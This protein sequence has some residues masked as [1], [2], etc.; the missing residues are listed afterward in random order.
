MLTKAQIFP[1]LFKD[2]WNAP[3]V[4]GQYANV[5]YSFF[6]QTPAYYLASSGSAAIDNAETDF[7]TTYINQNTVNSLNNYSGLPSAFYTSASAWMAV[8]NISITNV[9]D[10]NANANIA[11]MGASLK[12][13]AQSNQ[14]SY[15]TTVSSLLDTTNPYS[16]N[17]YFGDMWINTDVNTTAGYTNV[18]QNSA[19]QDGY[20]TILH[21]MGHALGL[22]HPNGDPNT[23]DMLHTVMS[24][25]TADILYDGQKWYPSEPM[26]YDVLAIQTLYG[27]DMTH[28]VG[29]NTP[30]YTFS[31]DPNKPD[32]KVIWDAGGTGDMIDASNQTLSV[33]I[34]MTPG[35]YSSIG[36]GDKDKAYIAIAYNVDGFGLEKN[37]IEN[38]SGGTANDELTGNDGDNLL[39]GNNGNDTLKGGIGNDTLNGGNNDDQLEGGEDKDE[40]N[41]NDG[42]DTLKGE[43][44]NDTL[45]GGIGDDTL[46]GCEDDDSLNGGEGNDIMNGD[47]GNDTVNGGIGYDILEGG[48]GNDTLYGGDNYDQLDGG[49]DDDRLEGEAGY[50]TLKGGSGSDVLKGGTGNDTLEGGDDGD[51]LD[52][53]E[54]NDLLDGGEGVDI[55]IGDVGND[56]LKGGDGND[57]LKA[58]AGNNLGGENDVLEGGEGIDTYQTDSGDKI[59]D[60]DGK[61]QVYFADNLLHGGTKKSG[62]TVWKDAD[63]H[64]TYELF[65]TKLLVKD[66]NTSL[67]I[68][69]FKNDDLGIHLD[70]KN[71]IKKPVNDHYTTAQNWVVPAKQCSFYFLNNST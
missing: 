50:D 7:L 9:G 37:Y 26:L 1:A 46:N 6:S 59:T 16:K 11:V 48:I 8:A 51:F 33:F 21:E 39:K 69:N 20:Q 38:A 5:S 23:E 24:Y 67:K 56:T 29:N 57:T 31:A 14:V 44:G 25:K 65:G 32:V 43:L 18:N 54:D 36:T 42:N 10:N 63:G 66:G 60:T 28:N 40:L 12:L 53:G 35:E 61:G 41:G 34:N 4:L 58:N 47:Y 70:T 17:S 2:S 22:Q 3:G 62:E 55:L 13:N 52:G 68:E 64:T 19:G 45:N 15:A 71:D 30:A 49:E 27:P